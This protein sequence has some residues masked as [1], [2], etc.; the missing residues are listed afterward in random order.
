[1]VLSPNGATFSSHYGR[2]EIEFLA[3]RDSWFRPVNMAHGP[4]GALYVCDMYR[5]VIE[6]PQFM[7][8]EL[9]ARP[10]LTLGN[11]RGRI[12]RVTAR[13]PTEQPHPGILADLSTAELAKLVT[14]PNVWQR[15]T[16]SRLI[17]E[18]D[19]KEAIASLKQT[20]VESDDAKTVVAAL[21]LLHRLKGLS[22]DVEQKLIAKRAPLVIEQLLQSKG[23]RLFISHYLFPKLQ[24]LAAIDHGAL[25]FR[26][27]LIAGRLSNTTAGTRLLIELTRHAD[28]DPWLQQAVLISA[29]EAPDEI[30]IALLSDTTQKNRK[31][32]AGM[33]HSLAALIGQRFKDEELDRTLRL[34]THEF[35]QPDTTGHVRMAL[36]HG[37]GDGLR[38]ANRALTIQLRESDPLV[39]AAANQTFELASR[40]AQ[41]FAESSPEERAK[42]LELLAFHSDAKTNDTL[43]NIIA[44][45]P[46][47]ANRQR[48]IELWTA[49]NPTEAAGEL[50][51]GFAA[52]TP[53]LRSTILTVL[54]QS[55]ASV[56]PLLDALEQKQI[57]LAE[58][59]PIQQ[60]LLQRHKQP[61][62]KSRID[63]LLA[64]SGSPDR[65]LVLEKYQESLKLAA[66]PKRGRIVFQKNCIA[67]HRIGD[68]GVNVAPDIADSRVAKPEVLLV[69][70]L[71]PNRAIDNNYFSYTIVLDSGKVLTGIIATETGN[72][73]TLR[74]PED[75]TVTILKDEIEDMKSDGISLMPVGLEKNITVQDMAD[76]ISFIKNWRYL[77]GN[78]PIDVGAAGR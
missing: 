9:K 23:E 39:Q 12:Y 66:D 63:K 61:E 42:C 16:A 78:V 10:D 4:D 38:R 60:R 54:S 49:N 7:P 74:Q 62:L 48:A 56:P 33:I 37:L 53:A 76:L 43:R 30:L 32:R 14:H 22:G 29:H 65:A 41:A 19:D 34:L 55:P 50:L 68:L 69:N 67:C 25:R 24:E 27:A 45:D 58:L 26:L 59:S 13:N 46:G 18:R 71:D 11:D 8:D 64:N 36:L 57:A 77:D 52:R 73:V 75:K 70:I 35:D 44:N 1:D 40:T 28:T 15:E 5:A 20:A 72:S 31:T 21:W 2:K 6:H 17:A 47:I 51:T 3:S